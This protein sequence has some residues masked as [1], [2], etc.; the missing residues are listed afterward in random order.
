M[1]L[2]KT[3]GGG[4]RCQNDGPFWGFSTYQGRHH[5]HD[6]KY[7]RIWPSFDF[8]L[9]MILETSWKPTSRFMRLGNLLLAGL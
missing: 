5:I 9:D 2:E 8:N 6:Q 7:G 4:Q 1:L 3:W